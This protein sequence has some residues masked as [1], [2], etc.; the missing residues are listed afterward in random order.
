MSEGVGKDGGLLCD[1]MSFTRTYSNGMTAP[2]QLSHFGAR[3]NLITTRKNVAN[4]MTVGY[5]TTCHAMLTSTRLAKKVH[6]I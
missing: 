3:M 4:Y 2:Y 6:T 5:G 1:V